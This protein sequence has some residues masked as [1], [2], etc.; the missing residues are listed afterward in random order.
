MDSND[1]VFHLIVARIDR[2]ESKV[3]Q[4]L[5]FKWK[6]VGLALAA[7]ILAAGIFETILAVIQSS[8]GG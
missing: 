6:V 2:I 8:R 1:K 5:E 3:D 4:L 7:G